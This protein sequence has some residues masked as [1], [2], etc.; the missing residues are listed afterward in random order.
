MV[1]VDAALISFSPMH[2]EGSGFHG[3]GIRA[4]SCGQ[5]PTPRR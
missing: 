5:A 2:A 3:T 1:A 4:Y